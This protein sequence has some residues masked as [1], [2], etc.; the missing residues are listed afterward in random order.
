MSGSSPLV[1]L[2][3]QIGLVILGPIS[4]SLLPGTPVTRRAFE[5]AWADVTFLQGVLQVVL[6]PLLGPADR[7]AALS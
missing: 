1:A 6:I 7:A 3:S 2:V 5:A 4:D